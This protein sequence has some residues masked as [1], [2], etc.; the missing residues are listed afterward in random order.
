MGVLKRISK[1]WILLKLTLRK[2]ARGG[3]YDQIGGG[4]ARY[5]TD[6]NWKVPHFEKMLYDNGQLISIYSQAYQKFK[7][8]EFRQVVYETVRFI[9]RELMDETG[10]FYSSWMPTVKGRREVLCLETE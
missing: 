4:F 9:E 10:A 2:M 5:S 6:E 8:E 1:R 3:I 7:D